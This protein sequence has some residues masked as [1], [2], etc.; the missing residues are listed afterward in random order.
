VIDVRGLRYTYAGA[1]VSAVR[2]LTFR[3]EKGEVFGFLGPSGAGK[4]TT[5][6]ILIALQRDYEGA[7]T[8]LGRD[9]RE[10]GA[11]YYEHIGVS[12]E[13]PNHYL[14]LTA[15]ENLALFRGFYRHSTESPE[16]VLE[17]VGL[18]E[19]ADKRVGAYSKGMRIRLNLA[20]ALLHQ[21][22]LL[23][24][25]EPTAGLDPATAR[26]VR[27]LIQSKQDAGTTV[28]LTTHDMT[29]ADALC[30]RVAFIVDGEIRLVDTPD[31][32]KRRYGQR[33]VRVTFGSDTRNEHQEFSLDGIADNADFLTLLRRPDLRTIH[34]LETTLEDVFVQV[35]GRGLA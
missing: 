21:P 1:P 31:V 24:L 27:L 11:D 29:A 15:R 13:F 33:A 8:V 28:F 7:V 23:F 12:F 2:D 35:T 32:L 6:K 14:K 3:V 4:S 30:S 5:Q 10:W 17:A 18:T 22:K 20:R 26:A 34:T 25:D 19:D 16:S 9:L